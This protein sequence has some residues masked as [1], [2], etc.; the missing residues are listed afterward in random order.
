MGKIPPVTPFRPR[1]ADESGA[2]GEP[3]QHPPARVRSPLGAAGQ[4]DTHGFALTAHPGQSQGRPPPADDARNHDRDGDSA[5]DW[6]WQVM[7]VRGLL[8]GSEMGLT[9]PH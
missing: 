8:P 1:D 2:G 4:H 3:G 9:L 5:Q 7:T 6:S